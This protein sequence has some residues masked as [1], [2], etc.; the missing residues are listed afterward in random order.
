MTGNKIQRASKTGFYWKV[1]ENKW[2][3]SCDLG[4]CSYVVDGDRQ[5]I[6]GYGMLIGERSL[7]LVFLF[8]QRDLQFTC[9]CGR[10]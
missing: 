1:W 8:E 3:F 2:V 9:V 6:P 5:I 4:V 10:P 7:A